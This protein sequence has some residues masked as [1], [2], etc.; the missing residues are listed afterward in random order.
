MKKRNRKSI[1]VNL[2]GQETDW[3][4]KEHMDDKCK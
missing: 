2:H 3:K 1:L 4:K